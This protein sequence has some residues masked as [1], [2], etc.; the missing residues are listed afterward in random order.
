MGDKQRRREKERGEGFADLLMNPDL[1]K[2][3][4]VAWTTTAPTEP[5]WYWLVADGTAARVVDVWFANGK[6]Y[7][8]QNGTLRPTLLWYP[9]PIEEP[10]R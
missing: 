7:W 6:L 8:G 1:E 9:V 5:G 10:P 2:S 4:P 3:P